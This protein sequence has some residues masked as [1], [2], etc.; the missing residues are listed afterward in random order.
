MKALIFFHLQSSHSHSSVNMKLVLSFLLLFFLFLLDWLLCLF[1]FLHF[2]FVTL[3]CP[4]W[5]IGFS[6]EWKFQWLYLF[7]FPSLKRIFLRLWFLLFLY[8]NIFQGLKSLDRYGSFFFF[9]VISTSGRRGSF[10]S[11]SAF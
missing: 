6:V 3:N 9:L 8:V 11:L 1:N 2:L 7:A 10:F 5:S 4:S